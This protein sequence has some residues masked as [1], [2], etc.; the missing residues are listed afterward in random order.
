MALGFGVTAVFFV[1]VGYR[2]IDDEKKRTDFYKRKVESTKNKLR[3]KYNYSDLEIK[4]LDEK[5]E[6]GDKVIKAR[7]TEE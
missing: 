1:Y 4:A 5:F 2:I 6:E 7:S 3:T